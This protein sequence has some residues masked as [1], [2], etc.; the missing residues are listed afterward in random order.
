ML[1]GDEFEELLRDLRSPDAHTRTI[2]LDLL[3]RKPTGDPRVLTAVEA[4]L[5]DDTPDVLSV[6][7]LFG[8]VRWAAAH[9]LAAERSASGVHLAVELRDVPRP[10]SLTELSDAADAAAIATSPTDN[11][12]DALLQSFAALRERGLLPMTT[13][14]LPAWTTG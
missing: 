14:R 6:P 7:Y 1:P 8:E 11:G 10:L 9:A 3:V 13:L 4:L 5:S 12:L 2:A